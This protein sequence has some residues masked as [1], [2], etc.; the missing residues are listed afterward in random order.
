[1][2]PVAISGGGGGGAIGCGGCGG[3]AIAACSQ[4]LH[5]Q[6]AAETA[7]AEAAIAAGGG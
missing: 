3:P 6:A 2:Q 4:C 5:M 1:M 7:V